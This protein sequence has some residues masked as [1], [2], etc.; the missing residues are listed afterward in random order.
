MRTAMD[1]HLQGINLDLTDDLRAYVEEKLADPLRLIAPSHRAGT[2]LRV[3]LARTTRRHRQ[4]DTL[5]RVSA[6]LTLPKGAVQAEEQGENLRQ[7]VVALKETLTRELR[8]L[9]ERRVE[10]GRRGARK[11]KQSLHDGES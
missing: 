8:Q 3:T 4:G 7:T 2:R 9:R 5:Y 6:H 10:A 1:M 11:A